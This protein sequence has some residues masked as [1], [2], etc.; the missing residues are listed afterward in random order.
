MHLAVEQFCMVVVV[1]D[2]VGDG[3]GD[4]IGNVVGDSVGD[5]VLGSSGDV[6]SQ[7]S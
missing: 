1:I 5:G 6:S 4:V 2:V 7:P 3:V